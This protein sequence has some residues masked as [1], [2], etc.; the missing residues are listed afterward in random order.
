MTVHRAKGLE[1]PVVILADPTAPVSH[2]EPS[3][4]VEPE[5]GLW[6]EALAGCMPAELVDHRAEVLAR[7]AEE[8]LRLAYVAATRARDLL[9]VPVTGDGPIDGWLAALDPV[10]YPEPRKRREARVA[11][12]CPRFGTDSV[13]E[14]PARAGRDEDGAVM[15][16]LHVSR[17]GTEVIWWD[18]AALPLG[19]DL[20]GGLRQQ[21]LLAADATGAVAE[22]AFLAHDAWAENRA[23]VIA[24]GAKETF[25]VRSVTE[26]ATVPREAAPAAWSAREREE[27][28][29]HARVELADTG[30]SRRGRPTGPRFGTFVHALLAT[31]PLDAGPAVTRGLAEAEGRLM[32]APRAEVE[33]AAAAVDAALRHPLLRRA[34]ACA[35]RDACR[36]ESPIVL[37]RRDGELIEGTVD[38]AFREDG[39]WTVVDFKTDAQIAGKQERYETQILLYVEAIREAT[40]EAAR[41][42]LLAV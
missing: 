15:P 19:K 14:R 12:S 40:G 16:G 3:R 38:L 4:H 9:V 32:G 20:E 33:A 37:P 34:A 23:L 29:A 30:V 17:A 7:D 25:A 10:L 11:A 2:G 27:P 13:L 22:E 1:F 42:V 8:N 35:R 21:R 24:Q 41:G 5:T 26:A 28:P 31:V 39:A 18:P 6:A 36:R